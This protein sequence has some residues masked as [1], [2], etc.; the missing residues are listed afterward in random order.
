MSDTND[1]PPLSLTVLSRTLSEIS[2]RLSEGIAARNA[3]SDAI[4]GK[5]PPAFTLT[6]CPPFYNDAD[7]PGEHSDKVDL[8]PVPGKVFGVDLTKLP[9][10][11]TEALL[12][13]AMEEKEL[14][15]FALWGRVREIS[16]M[17]EEV[18]SAI[19]R[20][21]EMSADASDMLSIGEEGASV[22]G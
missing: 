9:V 10:E 7:R 16:N 12:L 15:I 11:I 14:E 5:R 3:F 4:K 6:V 13:S 1:K 2:W 19:R 17:A 22:P 8:G 18:V 20:E 21:R